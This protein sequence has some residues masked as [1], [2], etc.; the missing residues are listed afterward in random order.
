MNQIHFACSPDI[1]MTKIKPLK[2][3]QYKH[4][5]M[6]VLRLLSLSKWLYFEPF[7]S[8]NF[9]MRVF[10]QS[11]SLQF[12]AT[13][14]HKILRLYRLN[15]LGGINLPFFGSPKVLLFDTFHLLKAENLCLKLLWIVSKMRM[16]TK[17]WFQRGF[18]PILV[19]YVAARLSPSFRGSSFFPRSPASR[20]T[21]AWP[22]RA[23][24]PHFG[25]QPVQQRFKKVN[26]VLS[27]IFKPPGRPLLTPAGP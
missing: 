9:I 19:L 15:S 24:Q 10:I 18:G 20:K 8:I 21:A 12:E 16:T 2:W 5:V 22:S 23:I 14:L 26:Q 7:L 6:I 17:M 3:A 27:N 25:P 1:K 13:C 4:E 11:Q